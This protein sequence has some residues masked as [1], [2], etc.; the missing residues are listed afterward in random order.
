MTASWWELTEADR[1][2]A[3]A[4]SSSTLGRPTHVIEKDL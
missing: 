2:D 3:I 1:K 4:F